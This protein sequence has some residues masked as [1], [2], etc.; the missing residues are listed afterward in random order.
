MTRTRATLAAALLLAVL[1]APRAAASVTT[2]K[3]EVHDGDRIEPKVKMEMPLTVLEA[4]AGSIREEAMS[5]IPLGEIEEHGFDLRAFWT[6]VRAA[7]ID[8]FFTVEAENCHVRGWREAGM[9]RLSV[10]SSEGTDAGDTKNVE[11]RVPEKLMDLVLDTDGNVTPADVVEAIRNAGP[12]TLVDVK[13]DGDS[14]RIWV[15]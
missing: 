9:F 11:I 8:E 4:L 6:K 15:E 5:H 3:I 14:V 10:V 7:N 1:S 13:S 12:M 2:L